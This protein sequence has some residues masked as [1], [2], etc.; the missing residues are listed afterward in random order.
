LPSLL[1]HAPLGMAAAYAHLF[2]RDSMQLKRGGDKYLTIY[3]RPWTTFQRRAM[4]A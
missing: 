2:P 1:R 3:P 4:C